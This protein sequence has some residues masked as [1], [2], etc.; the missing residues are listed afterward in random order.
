MSTHHSYEGHLNASG[1]SFAL[2]VARFNSFIVEQLVSGAI[3][4]MAAQSSPASA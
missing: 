1:R 2:V 4:S 3:T